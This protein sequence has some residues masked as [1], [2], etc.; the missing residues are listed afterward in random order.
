MLS[1]R[2]SARHVQDGVHIHAFLRQLRDRLR[3]REYEKLNVARVSSCPIQSGASR[4][5]ALSS[6]KGRSY[7]VG[8]AST[9]RSNSAN[10]AGETRQ[11]GWVAM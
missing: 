8:M 5:G 7:P 4:Q 9:A 3:C 11:S 1:V 6:R 2:G 10:T